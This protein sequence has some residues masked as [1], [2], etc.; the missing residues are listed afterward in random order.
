MSGSISVDYV[1]HQFNAQAN[2]VLVDINLNMQAEELISLIG[3]SGCSE[4]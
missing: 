2:A 3:R 1:S 4:Q